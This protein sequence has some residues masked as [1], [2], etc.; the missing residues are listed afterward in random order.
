MNS[1]GG[2]RDHVTNM[3]VPVADVYDEYRP[4]LEGARIAPHAS[5]STAVSA[6]LLKRHKET[7]H[8]LSRN[9]LTIP[10]LGYAP[11]F[12]ETKLYFG[13]E[14]DWAVMN[15]CQDPLFR[16]HGNRLFAPLSVVE[17]VQAVVAVGIN[18]DAIV[19]LSRLG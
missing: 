17:E 11:V 3:I 5:S 10:F 4:L 1:K 16:S 18:F 9:N 14:S 8:L 2:R 19:M 7:E 13:K 6:N 12:S 15:L